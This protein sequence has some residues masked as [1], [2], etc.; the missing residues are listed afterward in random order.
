M[1]IAVL[2]MSHM[3]EAAKKKSDVGPLPSSGS[4]CS[5]RVNDPASV[6][7]GIRV[8]CMCNTVC[9]MKCM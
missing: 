5:L 6:G 3:W 2:I 4:C 1:L 9:D 7:Q 8:K